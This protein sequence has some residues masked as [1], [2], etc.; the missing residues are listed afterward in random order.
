VQD[1]R[2]LE[3]IGSPAIEEIKKSLVPRDQ[4]QS[5]QHGSQFETLV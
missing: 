3:R 4:T 5:C 1:A 2:A